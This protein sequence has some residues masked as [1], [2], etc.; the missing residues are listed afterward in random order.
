MNKEQAINYLR[1]SGFSDKQIKAIYDAFT[2]DYITKEEKL[3]LE[4]CIV[5]DRGISIEEFG[6]A[7]EL[8]QEGG[9]A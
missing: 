2:N 8:L 5:N 7:L 3:F 6:E 1:C 9:K 4:T